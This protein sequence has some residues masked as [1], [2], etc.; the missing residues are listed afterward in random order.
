VEVE[1]HE[2]SQCVAGLGQ[3]RLCRANDLLSNVH[4]LLTPPAR[5]QVTS[6]T[7]I[8][9]LTLASPFLPNTSSWVSSDREQGLMV[10]HC[11]HAVDIL[12]RSVGWARLRT[13][14]R[15]AR[16]S[17]CKRRLRWVCRVPPTAGLALHPPEGY[18][19]ALRP[20]TGAAEYAWGA[21]ACRHNDRRGAS[22]A[23]SPSPGQD[24]R[25]PRHECP[26]RVDQH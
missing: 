17:S 23:S 16:V 19:P 1:A 20:L 21:R 11:C 15:V 6:A 26:A 4:V 10:H 25:R 22:T 2:L 3:A 8:S 9:A 18:Y 14:G 13:W 7:L 12:W 24:W 5:S